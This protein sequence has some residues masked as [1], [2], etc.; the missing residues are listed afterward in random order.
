VKR[1]TFFKGAAAAAL[2]ATGLAAWRA[3]D[4]GVFSTGGGPA[5]APWSDWRSGPEGPVR[6]VGAAILA[7][8]P[9][10]TQ[11]WRFRIGSDRI[12][13][14]AHEERHLGTMDPFRREMHI[15]LGCA[16]ENLMVAAPVDGWAAT[17]TLVPNPADSS[18][19][20]SVALERGPNFT[21]E[22]YDAIPKRHTNRGPY[23]AGAA[24]PADDLAHMQALAPEDDAVRMLWFTGTRDRE[25]LGQHI[26]EA[27]EAIIAD[28]EQSSDSARWFRFRWKAL[29]RER[30]GITLDAMGGPPLLRAVAK[31]MPPL[32][33]QRNDAF[34]L[35]FTRNV[36]VP[37]AAALGMLVV[38][39]VNDVAQRLRCGR[40]WQRAHLWA[41]S[42]GLAMQPLNQPIERIAREES[43]GLEPRFTRAL[44]SFAGG[45]GWAPLMVVRA[46]FPERKAYASPRRPVEALLA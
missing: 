37:T 30:D 24:I 46:G 28:E 5:Y 6:L 44:A 29:Q 15:G 10:N 43:R 39:D 32:S 19:V 1:R 41:T 22:A 38:R 3:W 25:V 36:H 42:R 12:D 20:A 35:D 7:A 11:P 31:F 33:R 9:H 23:R 21:P 8:S 17:A 45:S 40:L 27:T 34:W 16:L 4:Q 2:A 18:H 13:L 26:V 14:F